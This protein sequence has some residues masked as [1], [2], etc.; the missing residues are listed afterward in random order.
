MKYSYETVESA[1]KNALKVKCKTSE[2][3]RF[4]RDNGAEF[5]KIVSEVAKTLNPSNPK[6][7]YEYMLDEMDFELDDIIEE[8]AEEMESEEEFAE[9][10]EF[11]RETEKEMHDEEIA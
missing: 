4:C 8:T 2:D 11:E 9:E 5:D 1:M 7:A 3:V 10:E 6:E